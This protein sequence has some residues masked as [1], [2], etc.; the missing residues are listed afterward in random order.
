MGL[1]KLH[2]K[3]RIVLWKNEDI[4]SSWEEQASINEKVELSNNNEEKVK[5]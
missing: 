3:Y 1:P 4:P 2:E 5:C